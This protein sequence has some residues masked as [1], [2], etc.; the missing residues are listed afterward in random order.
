MLFYLNP[1]SKKIK[2]YTLE[3]INEH[4]F[5]S[6]YSH[7]MRHIFMITTLKKLLQDP[8]MNSSLLMNIH[9]L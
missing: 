1:Y 5:T 9:M 2:F 7:A 6:N 8:F 4:K 3:H